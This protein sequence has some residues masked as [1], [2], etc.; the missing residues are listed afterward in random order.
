MEKAIRTIWE[1]LLK[2]THQKIRKKDPI[3]T[4]QEINPPLRTEK[5]TGVPL[6]GV[7]GKEL[8]FKEKYGPWSRSAQGSKRPINADQR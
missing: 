4:L 2:G 8:A 5:E 7:K 3:K 1:Y 6:S